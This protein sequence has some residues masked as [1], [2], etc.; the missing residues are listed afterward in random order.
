MDYDCGADERQRAEVSQ[1][2]GEFLIVDFHR[3]R[4]DKFS[5]IQDESESLTSSRSSAA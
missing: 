4:A 1:K 3:L 5:G 2:T